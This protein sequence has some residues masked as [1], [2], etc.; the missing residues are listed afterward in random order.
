MD[1]KKILKKR[2]WTG[3]EVGQTLMMS[4]IN[5]IKNPG[6]PLFTQAD[7]SRIAGSLSTER[8]ICAYEVYKD[9][10]FA[11]IDSYDAGTTQIHRFRHGHAKLMAELR[12][13]RLTERVQKAL[14]KRETDLGPLERYDTLDSLAGDENK[15]EWLQSLNGQLITPAFRYM[16]AHN[17]LMEIIGD[18]YDIEGLG[19]G[20]RFK[21]GNYEKMIELYTNTL[22]LFKEETRSKKKKALIGTLFPTVSDPSELKPTQEAIDAVKA[23]VG[24]NG[25]PGTVRQ[26]LRPLGGIIARLQQR[27]AEGET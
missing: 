20:A 16:Y 10:F 4:L 25:F 14:G 11:V 9:L 24:G 22:L 1:I 5:D 15:R 17:T 6:R 19:E 27:G 13:V 3:K 2:R 12:E 18:A 21:T 26:R 7:F 23:E 8:E